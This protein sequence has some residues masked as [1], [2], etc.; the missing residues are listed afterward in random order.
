MHVYD[1]SPTSPPYCTFVWWW[2]VAWWALNTQAGDGDVLRSGFV[3]DYDSPLF[4]F[5]E[6][7][8]MIFVFIC[9][10]LKFYKRLCQIDTAGIFACVSYLPLFDLTFSFLFIG[11]FCCSR[12]WLIDCVGHFLFSSNIYVSYKWK[13]LALIALSRCSA[14][15]VHSRVYIQVTD[16][17]E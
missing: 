15:I 13:I 12:T 6:L 3:D 4:L 8:Y 17:V 16:A 5:L 2:V 14:R 11:L 1:I 7:F 10:R 9:I